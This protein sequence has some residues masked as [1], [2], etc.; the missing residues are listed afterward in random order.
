MPAP[1]WLARFNRVVTNNLTRTF[2]TRSPGFGVVIH[3]GRRSGRT[4]RTPVNVFRSSDGYV[5]ALTY[6][7]QAD[8]VKNVLSAGTCQLETQGNI[9]SL[10]SPRL[11]H[12]ETRRPVPPFVRVP[13]GLAH[14]YDFLLLSRASV[15][16]HARFPASV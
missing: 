1:R 5:I 12:D 11:V 9:I 2:V 6:G 15:V 4:Y 3:R 7:P 8:W 16:T 13:L 14:V 10:S